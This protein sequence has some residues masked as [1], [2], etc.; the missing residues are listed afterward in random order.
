MSLVYF[1]GRA[2]FLEFGDGYVSTGYA[3]QIGRPHLERHR[4]VVIVIKN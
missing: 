4:D 3:Q 1:V 2:S